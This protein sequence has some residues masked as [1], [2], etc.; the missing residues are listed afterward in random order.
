MT[1]DRCS[2]QVNI[3]R[4][5]DGSRRRQPS[6]RKSQLKGLKGEQEGSGRAKEEEGKE[7][8][9]QRQE[10]LVTQPEDRL[11]PGSGWGGMSCDGRVWCAV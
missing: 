11:R 7:S 6:W 8:P 5:A 9:R 3:R 2:K 10:A 1:K 4:A